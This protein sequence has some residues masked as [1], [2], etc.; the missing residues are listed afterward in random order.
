[1]YLKRI[2]NVIGYKNL[3]DGF[4]MDFDE[5]NNYIIGANFQGKSTIGSLFN[6]CLT[7]TNLYGKE[8]EQVANDKKRVSNVIVDITFVDNYGIEHRLIR[9]KSKEFNITLDDKEIKQDILSKYYKDK[10]VFLVAHNPYYFYSLEP[11][12][13]KDVL[14]KIVPTISA[15]DSYKL[16]DEYDKEI[17]KSPIDNLSSYTNDRNAEINELTKEHDKNEG[18]L[19]AFKEMALKSAGTLLK[20]DKQE[21]LENLQSKYDIISKNFESSNLEDLQKSINRIDTQ[22]NEIMKVKLNEILEHYKQENSKLKL[23]KEQ[24]PVCPS[25]RQ[26]IKDADSKNH[27][28]YFSQKE[29]Q[30]LQQKAD[31]LKSEATKLINEKNEKTKIYERLKTQDIEKINNEKQLLETRINELLNEQKQIELNNREVQARQEQ[32]DEAKRRIDFTEE[33]QKEILQN[34]KQSQEQKKIA[35]KLKILIIEKQKEMISKYLNKVDIQ[36]SKVNKTGEITE[37]CNIQYEGRDYKKL[38]KSQQI[39]AS[40]EISNVFNNLSGIK[41]PIFLDDAE[42]T[43]DIE[44]IENTQ[45]IVSMVVK[46]NPLEI[47]YN[48][49]EVLEKRRASLDREIEENIDYLEI[50]A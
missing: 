39:R 40:L 6:W 22:L 41:A 20:F 11:K 10:D 29:L 43:T 28:I 45:M 27:L 5:K 34:L 12:E 31:E 35:N 37:C 18:F 19:Q 47:V 21:E 46:Y 24:K 25:C 23:L 15:E 2:N 3:P 7:G 9:N 38:S 32:I 14:R 30:R 36:F 16:L 26:E 48:Y 8:K 33:V 50:V 4:S 13:Q 42:S 49:D 17:V 1:M 44:K